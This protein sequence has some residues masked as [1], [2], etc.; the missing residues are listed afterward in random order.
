MDLPTFPCRKTEERRTSADAA[1]RSGLKL[2][3]TSSASEGILPGPD[4]PT[5]M[6]P[7]GLTRKLKEPSPLKNLPGL[8]PTGSS[9]LASNATCSGEARRG[10]LEVSFS[11]TVKVLPACTLSGPSQRSSAA[12]GSGS[13]FAGALAA[14]FAGAL[15]ADFAGA[16]AAALTAGGSKS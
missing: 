15:A 4:A 7:S 9:S 14:D 16:L 1:G 12:R 10:S 2:S 8:T 5:K 3:T 11:V 13:D 6:W